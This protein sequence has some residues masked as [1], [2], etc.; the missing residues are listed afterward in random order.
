[1]LNFI[2]LKII[3]VSCIKLYN[4]LNDQFTK[5]HN[6][7]HL[8]NKRDLECVNV[9]ENWIESTV[10]LLKDN[11]LSESELISQYHG[12]LLI[13]RLRTDRKM[14]KRKR[15][16][17]AVAELINPLKETITKI[18]EPVSNK[19]KQSKIIVNR[20]LSAKRFNWNEGLNYRD[21]I[22]AVWRTLLTEHNTQA[23]ANTLLK[24][25]GEDDALKLIASKLKP[26]NSDLN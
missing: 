16:F 22:L 14:P 12:Q 5:M 8:L 3:N 24:L 11:N 1:M 4:D 26:I 2:E 17:N 25:V 15:E 9:L 18:I 23:D 10:T 6:I 20:M 7:T 21:Y 19:L 13:E